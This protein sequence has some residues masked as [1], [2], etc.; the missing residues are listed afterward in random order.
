MC[1]GQIYE[2]D[3]RY[4]SKTHVL[5]F[6]GHL[7]CLKQKHKNSPEHNTFLQWVIY[8]FFF[9]NNSVFVWCFL[10]PL[11]LFLSV[12]VCPC[13]VRGNCKMAAKRLQGM[14]TIQSAVGILLGT[15][16]VIGKRLSADSATQ[17]QFT[18]ST[19]AGTTASKL[20]SNR[21]WDLHS[22]IRLLRWMSGKGADFSS[23]LKEALVSC[24]FKMI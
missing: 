19:S 21:L 3:W 13:N 16:A 7:K 9:I 12:T 20:Q 8:L 24:W 14:P 10:F 6:Q 15:F 2:Q 11:V 17:T 18:D 1:Y 4:A 22:Y 5:L 23:C